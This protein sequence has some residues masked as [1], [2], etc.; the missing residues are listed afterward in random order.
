VSW[1]EGELAACRL[2][3]QRLIKRLGRLLNQLGE[4]MDQPLP[5]ACQDWANTKARRIGF[6]LTCGWIKQPFK[7]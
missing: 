5:L 7:G 4:A 3:D 2:G 1:V 6:S